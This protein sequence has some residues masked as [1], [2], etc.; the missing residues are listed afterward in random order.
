M[1][2]L[3]EL[4]QATD[5]RVIGDTGER[6]VLGFAYDSRADCRDRVFVAIRTETGDGHEYVEAAV[7]A[8][9]AAVLCERVPRAALAV[10][11]LVVADVLAAL[12]DWATAAVRCW[13]PRI[14]AITGGVG[15]TTTKELT[16][17]VLS[18][19]YRVVASPGNL[20][21]RLGLPVALAEVERTAEVAVLELAADSFGELAAL[22]A[23]A[24]PDAV[25]VTNVCEPHLDVFGS[26][27]ASAAEIVRVVDRLP[28]TGVA[29]LNRDDERAWAMRQRTTAQVV[30]FGA[31]GDVRADGVRLDGD[32]LHFALTADGQTLPADVRLFSPALAPDCL[33]AVATGLALGVSLAEATT[34]LAAAGPVAGR[35]SPVPALSGATILDDTFS[36]CPTSTLAA[37]AGL[38]AFPARRRL[39]ALGAPDDAGTYGDWL[40]QVAT[41]AHAA[42]HVWALGDAAAEVVRRLPAG[43]GEVFYSLPELARSL[44]AT[45]GAGD[46]L[47]VK[48]GRSSRLERLVAELATPEAR[49]HLVRQEAHWR[50][51]RLARPERPTW[52]EI[53]VEAL[54]ENTRLLRRAV[55][56]P[57][58][59][60]LKADAYGHGAVRV[61]RVVM[62]NGADSL[63]VACLSEAKVLRLAGVEAPLLVLGYTPPWQARECVGLRV[64][65]TLFGYEDAEAF[66][67]AALALGTTATVH[68]KV[69]TGM[70]RL[71]LTPEETPPFIAALRRLAGLSVEG[72]FTHF[73]SADSPGFPY[74]DLQLE[75]FL[76][77]L[78][79]LEGQGLRPPVAHAA[80][81]AA[82][83]TLPA[84][85]LD[86]VRVGIGLYGL[87]PS[88]AV[89]LPAGCR[90]VLGFKTTVVQVHDVS[91]GTYV[92]YG[93]AHLTT[94]SR[95][96]A[97][98]PVGYADGF[99][100][101]PANWGEVLI[102]GHRC[103]IIG[104]VCM[105]Q[106]MVDVSE[107]PEVAKGDEV[108]LIGRQGDSGI[109]ADEVA[110]RLGT[111]SYEV[112]SAILARVPRTV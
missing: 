48:G 64:A 76:A 59:A 85:R 30:S 34:G 95:R 41:A 4:I 74:T 57:L 27:E 75:R 98:I 101:G 88:A 50:S 89:A 47:L 79:A 68:V 53:D 106:A 9:A 67:R 18:R 14:V 100:R 65:A 23:I 15:K 93:Q 104:S 96:L 12:A 83:L 62:A 55:G 20:S 29:V 11:V 70:A 32:G 86:A 37:F 8:G 39:L 22:A 112:V 31:G 105:D 78:A 82:A 17:A 16:A 2:S 72:I 109:T 46:V 13:Q 71:G 99:R 103:P 111:I 36:A 84:A 69:D 6:Q 91:A 24:P 81:T 5:A 94:D 80:N 7:A 60:V 10:P 21:G 44:A 54:A 58:M 45:L 26:L 73:G 38:A 108:V 87:Q 77:L 92:G 102:R 110:A 90:P 66:S 3:N 56:V 107:A 33:A 49:G 51:V 35:L 40:P 43:R 1:L 61:A 19:R 25:V 97:T 28:P 63:A 52:V 42:D